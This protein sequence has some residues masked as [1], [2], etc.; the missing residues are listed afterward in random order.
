MT[1]V[2]SPNHGATNRRR[3]IKS[4]LALSS[5]SIISG[6]RCATG[7]AGPLASRHGPDTAGA[8]CQPR[9]RPSATTVSGPSTASAR[10]I[11]GGPC[12]SAS[13]ASRGDGGLALYA[14]GPRPGT[15]ACLQTNRS[16]VYFT[17]STYQSL[18]VTVR[19]LSA[20]LPVCLSVSY[21]HLSTATATCGGFTAVVPAG[22]QYRSIAAAGD[23]AQQHGSQQQMRAVSRCQTA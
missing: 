16:I 7:P 20:Y 1:T 17:G 10:C 6:C 9:G 11:A 2:K 23:G 18:Y 5:P 15:C 19:H 3:A 21:S 8:P 14:G 4:L 22:R 13:S 12:P